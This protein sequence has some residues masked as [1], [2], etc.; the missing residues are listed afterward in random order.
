[1]IPTGRETAVA[2]KKGWAL[3]RLG[4]RPFFLAAGLLAVV[5]MSIWMAVLL[6]AVPL[7]GAVSPLYW[8]A[9][10][11]L[12][13]YALAVIAGFLLTA[14]RNW[15]GVPT[16]SG[17]PLR[18]L[19]LLWLLARVAALL[20]GQ[21]ALMV[22]L[23]FDCLF[24][25]YL[26]AALT[27][28]VVKVKQWKSMGVV[29]KL[30][31]FLVGDLIYTLGSFGLLEG[32]QRIG[33]EIALY[34]TLS[35][36]LVLS[37]RVV[38]M[39]VE[40]GVGYPVGLRNRA[41]VDR[42]AFLT[43]LLFAVCEIFFAQPALTAWLALAL[44]LLHAIR[45]QGWYTHGIWRKPLLW[46]LF[47][48]YGWM[49]VGFALKFAEYALNIPF[50]LAIHAFTVGGI[51]MMTLAMMSRVAL[52]HTGR[53]IN[54]PPTVVGTMLTLLCGAAV[55]RVV[56]PLLSVGYDSIWLGLSQLLWVAAFALFLYRYTPILVRPRADGRPG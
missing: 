6:F 25:I 29:S 48:A 14:V 1:M 18:L 31:F 27:L 34:M 9:H 10:E 22:G 30:Y 42:S 43:F 38:P 46:G 33:I 32:G 20:P 11:M 55:A 54:H 23:A 52:G 4:F 12:Y 40:R 37:R 3:F 15:T 28:P 49:I 50:S 21:T 7:P 53:D 8:H 2:R 16:L 39:F 45:L 47:I 51:G 44:S 17:Q 24:I 19:I 13:G 36:I 56:L 35:L 41:W 5:G 26:S